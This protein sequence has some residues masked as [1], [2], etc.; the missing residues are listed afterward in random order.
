MIRARIKIQSDAAAFT[1]TGH[2][3]AADEGE[4]IVCAAV[5]SAAYL[6]AN[7]VTEILKVPAKAEVREGFMEFSF[8]GSKP[9]ADLVRGF[10]LHLRE[11]R[12]Q[13]P[14]NIKI[15][16]EVEPCLR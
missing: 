5:S 6:T 2:A 1:L 8:T 11:L 12:K 10:L 9:A 15:L 3:D 4:D 7:T 13:Y 14:A 16:T